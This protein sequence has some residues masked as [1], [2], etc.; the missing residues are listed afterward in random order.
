[1]GSQICVQII[2][3][4][5]VILHNCF[6][7]ERI[8]NGEVNNFNKMLEYD[9]PTTTEEEVQL[10]QLVI[11]SLKQDFQEQSVHGL[12]SSDHTLQEQINV[13]EA[14][15]LQCYVAKKMGETLNLD[16]NTLLRDSIINHIQERAH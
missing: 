16:S 8:A 12:V 5:C 11:E 14:L 7:K 4:A 3:Q 2:A 1:M 9:A 6:S 13:V 10:E 15:S